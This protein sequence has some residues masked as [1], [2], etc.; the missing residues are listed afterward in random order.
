MDKH[1]NMLL[2]QYVYYFYLTVN[3]KCSAACHRYQSLELQTTKG[4]HLISNGRG[5]LFVIYSWS[6]LKTPSSANNIG[7]KSL[8]KKKGVEDFFS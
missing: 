6:L 4:I 8:Y 5:V 7:F 2:M 1:S 3:Q